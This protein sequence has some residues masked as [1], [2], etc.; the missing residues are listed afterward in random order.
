MFWGPVLPKV[1][2]L[3]LGMMKMLIPK[4]MEG[5]GSLFHMGN[6]QEL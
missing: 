1:P 2:G 3:R 5:R 4:S 6:D